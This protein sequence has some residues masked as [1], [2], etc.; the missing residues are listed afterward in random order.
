MGLGGWKY[1]PFGVQFL[2][3]PYPTPSHACGLVCGG[4]ICPPAGGLA[5]SGVDPS[6]HALT[7]HQRKHHPKRTKRNK[8]TQSTRPHLL[9]LLIFLYCVIK[10]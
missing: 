1:P 8:R 2:I 4:V 9:E 7:I 3:L 10:K 6:P 5:G